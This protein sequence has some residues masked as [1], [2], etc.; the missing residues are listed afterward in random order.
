MATGFMLQATSLYRV[1]C[2][3]YIKHHLSCNRLINYSP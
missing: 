2:G 3:A 1:A